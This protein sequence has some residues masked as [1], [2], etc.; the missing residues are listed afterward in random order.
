MNDGGCRLRVAIVIVTSHHQQRQHS[1]SKARPGFIE[2]TPFV[3]SDK[4]VQLFN[5]LFIVT[6]L[7]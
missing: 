7:I 3:T 5:K 1:D 6:D 2:K 4:G